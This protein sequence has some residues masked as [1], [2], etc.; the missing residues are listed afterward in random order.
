M[1]FA[2]RNNAAAEYR[3]P[4]ANDAEDVSQLA[5]AAPL[6]AIIRFAD[7]GLT[8]SD[9][10]LLQKGLDTW[11]NA[12]GAL[13]LERCLGLPSTHT[14]VRK[15]RRNHWLCKAAVLI[16]ADG[17]STASQKLEA[18]WNKFLSRGPWM[19]WRDDAEP[20]IE[21]SQLNQ[22]LF[23]ATRYNRSESLTARH[24]ARIIGHI[25]TEKCR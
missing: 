10:V 25:F 17:I 9:R 7:G 4:R 24:I 8:E 22:A 6:L 12:G 15:F 19:M 5:G 21:A 18:E 14:R 16:D 13:P 11:L 1:G 3:A 2:F 23:W 20:P